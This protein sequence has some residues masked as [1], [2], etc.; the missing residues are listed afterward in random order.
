MLLLGIEVLAA[1]EGTRITVMVSI[2]GLTRARLK[3]KI[4]IQS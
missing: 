3:K 4:L 2:P 1:N